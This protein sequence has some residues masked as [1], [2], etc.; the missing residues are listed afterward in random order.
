MRHWI[1]VALVV[2]ALPPV[3]AQAW[4]ND[5]H[6]AVARIAWKQLSDAQRAQAIAIL[7]Q[8]P[9]KAFLQFQK[10]A[11][12]DM[13]EWMF[14]QAATWPDWVRKPLNPMIAGQSPN[15]IEHKYSRPVW[16]YVNLPFVMPGEDFDEAQIRQ[17]VLEPAV[18][19]MGSPRH[20]LAALKL[21]LD[22][23]GA[24][25]TSDEDRAVSLCWVLHLSG[26]VH[27]P[28]HS[29]SLIASKEKVGQQGF[30]PLEGDRGGNSLGVKTHPT[31]N[32]ATELHTYWDALLLADKPYSAVA[33]KTDAWMQDLGRDDFTDELMK[34]AFSDWAD[35]S[36]ALAK[37]VA[38]R[39]GPQLIAFATLPPNHKPSDLQ[40]LDAPALSDTYQAAA[41]KTAQKQM[42]LGGYRLA[43]KLGTVWPTP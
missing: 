18:D 13:N 29:A 37:S 11:D 43:D 16:H 1:L 5:G 24:D 35:E 42:V 7:N 34:T 6:K 26:D 23:L 20:A 25:G 28:L 8:H 14:V 22:R 31:N 21:N 4:H 41:E 12:T 32:N 19:D 36:L 27:Q 15:Q 9:H 38:Y 39:D 17:Q 3:T 33:S 10:P 2:C 40:G 30:L